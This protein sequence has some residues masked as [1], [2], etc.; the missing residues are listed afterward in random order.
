MAPFTTSRVLGAITQ[1][2]A[3]CSVG[4]AYP[5]LV[6][7]LRSRQIGIDDVADSYDYIIVGGGQSG[8]VIASRLSEDESSKE[9]PF[10]FPQKKFA[11][12]LN[13][14]LILIC[15]ATPENVLVVEYGYFDDNPAQLEPSSAVAY[16][17]KDMYN[18]TS[19]PLEHLSGRNGVVYAAAVMGGGSTINGMMLNRGSPEDYDNWGA[20]GNPGWD[21]EGLLPYFKKVRNVVS[22]IY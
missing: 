18:L 21:W 17:S 22:F 16:P 7:D 14:R 19:A 10:P 15:F 12:C 1:L 6:N 3:L 11:I 4:Q 20:M 9:D 8:V 5:S 13:E 2:L